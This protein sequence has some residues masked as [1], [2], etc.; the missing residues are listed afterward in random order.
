MN[1]VMDRP[2]IF[3]PFSFALDQYHK[4][5]LLF[6]SWVVNGVHWPSAG[7]NDRNKSERVQT[8]Q[9]RSGDLPHAVLTQSELVLFPPSSAVFRGTPFRMSFTFRYSSPAFEGHRQWN[10]I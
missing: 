9:M 8:L 3:L 10:L 6:A 1:D 2:L 4:Q 7:D 5:W